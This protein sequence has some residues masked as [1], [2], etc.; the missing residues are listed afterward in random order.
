MCPGNAYEIFLP[1]M[2]DLEFQYPS[3]DSTLARSESAE[4]KFWRDYAIN[5]VSTEYE[6]AKTGISHPVI[7]TKH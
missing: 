1:G 4:S 3:G 2:G 7:I 5:A 6:F